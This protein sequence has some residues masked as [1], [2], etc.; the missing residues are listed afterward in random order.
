MRSQSES[1][2]GE[3]GANVAGNTINLAQVSKA[4]GNKDDIHIRK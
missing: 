2:K 4:E 1:K 3:Q